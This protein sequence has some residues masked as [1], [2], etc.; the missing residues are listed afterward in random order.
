MR[1]VGSPG[2][3]RRWEAVLD[4]TG[5]YV[6]DLGQRI[7]VRQR[8]DDGSLGE[9]NDVHWAACNA[10]KFTLIMMG[11]S[12]RA[13]LLEMPPSIMWRKMV[14]FMRRAYKE[15]IQELIFQELVRMKAQADTKTTISPER[16]LYMY[17]AL[18]QDPLAIRLVVVLP[19][20]LQTL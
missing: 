10:A 7:A 14:R 2:F 9:I 15:E 11:G 20:A 3:N 4:D 13:T 8:F 1:L 16:H 6:D 5:S 18:L 17:P 19:S 12:V